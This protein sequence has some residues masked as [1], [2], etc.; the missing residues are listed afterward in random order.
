MSGGQRVIETWL[1]HY[2]D[3]GLA[4]RLKEEFF[5]I[6]LSQT[7]L[8]ARKS[9]QEWLA[10]IPEHHKTQETADTINGIREQRDILIFWLGSVEY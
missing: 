4:Y 9:Y 7:E 1:N 2:P 10:K 8:D 5:D 3:L 6:W